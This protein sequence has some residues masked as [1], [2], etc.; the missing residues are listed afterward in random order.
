M[1]CLI[2]DGRCTRKAIINYDTG[3]TVNI[4]QRSY[5]VNR[6]EIDVETHLVGT[7]PR[8]ESNGSVDI[9]EYYD[10]YHQIHPGT[11]PFLQTYIF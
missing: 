11:S 7:V 4:T 2:S 3:E 9:E 5:K 6:H 10:L 1:D 8:I